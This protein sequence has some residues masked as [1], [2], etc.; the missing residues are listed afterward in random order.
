MKTGRIIACAMALAPWWCGSLPAATPPV[1]GTLSIE[2][3][4]ADP[5]LAAAIPTF[6]EMVGDALT[7]R[8]FTLLEEPG[9]AAFVVEIGVMRDEVGTA[10]AKVPAG[11][12][13]VLPGA[14]PAVGVGVVVPFST[15]QSTLVP[16]Q[17]TRLDVRFRKR[18]E[19]G[20]TWQGAAVTVR[21]A[22]TAKGTDKTV[23]ADL[24]QALLRAYPAQPEG[25]IGVP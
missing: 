5:N 7:A 17:R 16:L 10:S 20:V 18:G 23:A 1:S 11:H 15:G 21:A 3:N 12:S 8:G 25:V 2:A 9:H 13:Q 14:S 6:V 4:A 22:R 19:D 24:I